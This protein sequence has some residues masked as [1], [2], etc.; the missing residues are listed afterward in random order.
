MKRFANNPLLTPGDL[1]PTRE[2]LEIFCTLNPAAVVFG[3]E[4]LLLVR[5]GEKPKETDDKHVATVMYDAEKGQTR[6][7]RIRRDDPDFEAVDPRTFYYKGKMLLT[8][9]SHLRLARSR[10]GGKTFTFDPQPAIYPATPYE[11]F[12]CEDARITFIDGEY[13]ITYTAVSSRGVAVA[14]AYTKDFR[15][16]T[17]VGIIFPPFQKDV[18]IFPEKVRNMYVARHRPWRSEFNDPCIW[19]AYSPDLHAWGHHE[20][21]LSTT[22]GTWEA[23]RV[24]AGAP[25]IK[26]PHGW[27][28]IYHAADAQGRYCLGA[29]L[30]DLDHPE[31]ILTRG[32]EPIF[33]AE[34]PYEVSGVYGNCVFSNG[35]ICDAD[36]KMIVYYGAADRICAAATTTVQEMIAAARNRR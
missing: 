14:M 21:T 19:T 34:A 5:V 25:P 15:E 18:C 16:F 12:G 13:F 9:L 30:S 32:K 24:G 31:R 8:S 36:G 33:C 3:D 26:T 7:L 20:L 4:V 28:D 17:R 35:L 6:L 29:M 10:D 2:D 1:K 27:L 23:G 22:P 11:A